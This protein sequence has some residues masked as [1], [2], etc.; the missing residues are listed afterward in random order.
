MFTRP[1][2]LGERVD[3]RKRDAAGV[4]TLQRGEHAQ[5]RGFPR[6]VRS[7]KSEHL[8]AR[9]VE[10][11]TVQ[12]QHSARIRDNDIAGGEHGLRH[13]RLSRRRRRDSSRAQNAGGRR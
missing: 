9:H 11:D 7:K 12:C 1:F 10:R 3:A 2:R 5:Q 8:A 13:G 6:A 4:G